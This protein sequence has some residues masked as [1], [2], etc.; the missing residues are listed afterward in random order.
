MKNE[1]SQIERPIRVMH[2]EDNQMDAELIHNALEEH[3]IPCSITRIDSRPAFEAALQAER[4]DLIL[5]D[6]SLPSFDTLGALV[7]ARERFPN[8][9]FIFVSGSSSPRVKAEASRLGAS[10]FI[11]KDD[12]SR[13][14]RVVNWLFLVRNRESRGRALP[15]VGAPVMVHCKGFRCLGYLDREG[16]WRDFKTSTELPD[17]VDWSDF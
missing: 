5:S 1:A 11:S 17:A 9:P 8:I 6:S 4:V 15:E 10:D 13:L 12:L 14:A 3:H 7:L 2:L 16:K